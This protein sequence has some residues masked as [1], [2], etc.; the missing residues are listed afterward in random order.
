MWNNKTG[1]VLCDFDICFCTKKMLIN[2]TNDICFCTKKMLINGTNKDQNLMRL[3]QKGYKNGKYSCSW[4]FT[5]MANTCTTENDSVSA[6]F[7]VITVLHYALEMLWTVDPWMLFRAYTCTYNKTTLLQE[8]AIFNTHCACH[9]HI[10][11]GQV[12]GPRIRSRNI[13]PLYIF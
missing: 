8:V 3:R 5:K 11:R 6:C 9:N 2:G 4:K 12:I 13:S 10:K 7:H 1:E